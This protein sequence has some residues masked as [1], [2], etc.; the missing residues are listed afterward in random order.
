MLFYFLYNTINRETCLRGVHRHC[1]QLLRWASWSLNGPSILHMREHNILCQTGAQQGDPLA[2]LL[3]SLGLHEAIE[4]G[5]QGLAQQW[6]L[7][8]GCRRATTGSGTGRG[9]PRAGPRFTSGWDGSERPK[10]W[11]LRS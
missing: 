3:F 1:P 4:A 7:D 5:A 6:F 9:S 2:P 10:M 11:V 8:E